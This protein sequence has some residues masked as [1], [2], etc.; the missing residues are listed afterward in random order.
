MSLPQRTR[1]FRWTG[2][3]QQRKAHSGV[4]G[5]TAGST[6]SLPKNRRFHRPPVD[7][8][9]N[10]CSLPSG[11]QARQRVGDSYGMPD[12]DAA[13]AKRLDL[14]LSLRVIACRSGLGLAVL[15][16]IGAA[17]HCVDEP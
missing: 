6:P 11:I 7:H 3:S 5:L 16:E 13:P 8:G 2:V 14:C 1:P 17:H 4:H 12:L 10:V 9:G 15:H